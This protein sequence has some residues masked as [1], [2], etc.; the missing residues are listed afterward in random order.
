MKNTPVKEYNVILVALSLLIN[1]LNNNP[2]LKPK[3]NLTIM[4][5]TIVSHP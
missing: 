1:N 4:V 2:T 3:I 5:L